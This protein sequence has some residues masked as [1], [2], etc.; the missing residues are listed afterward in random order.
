[1]QYPR[2]V[3]VLYAEGYSVTNF[4]VAKSGRQAF[5]AFLSDGMRQ[6]WD[7]AVQTHYRYRS[8]REL[9]EAWMQHLRETPRES[10]SAI[11]SAGGHRPAVGEDLATSSPALVRRTLPPAF[12]VL[13][14]PRPVARGVAPSS[15]EGY[16]RPVTSGDGWAVPSAAPA[17]GG[18][19]QGAGPGPAVRLGAPQPLDSA[20]SWGRPTGGSPSGYS[21]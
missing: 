17:S 11:A 18:A 5:L 16:T 15:E 21:P 3:M 12:P 1:M 9:E 8:V 19:F 6:G 14:A 13:G 10:S 7:H 2:D 4:L 20:P